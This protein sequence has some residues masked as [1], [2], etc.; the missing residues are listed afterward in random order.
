MKKQKVEPLYPSGMQLNEDEDKLYGPGE[1]TQ[2]GVQ[3]DQE[4]GQGYMMP[5]MQDDELN[6]QDT[7]F[8]TKQRPVQSNGKVKPLP[9]TGINFE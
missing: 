3:E 8:I 5:P 1:K 6:D 2:E 9:P 4:T 7:P